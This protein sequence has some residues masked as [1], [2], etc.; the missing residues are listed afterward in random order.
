MPRQASY[1][2]ARKPQRAFYR[3]VVDAWP[4]CHAWL[5]CRRMAVTSYRGPARAGSW[6]S[7]SDP[8]M[9]PQPPNRSRPTKYRRSPRAVVSFLPHS[10]LVLVQH[11]VHGSRTDSILSRTPSGGG[12][13]HAERS[14]HTLRTGEPRGTEYA[15]TLALGLTVR[16]QVRY[17]LP[18]PADRHQYY[19][20]KRRGSQ[21]SSSLRGDALGITIT[22]TFADRR[23]AAH[24]PRAGHRSPV[25][26]SRLP[27][28]R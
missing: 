23:A 28:I 27:D 2:D 10:T 18:A 20:T 24:L 11:C 17:L 19:S 14:T 16:G 21:H 12:I 9:V 3:Q 8:D 7:P 26:P 15:V 1:R 13:T 5:L 4:L 25:G 22:A 6:E